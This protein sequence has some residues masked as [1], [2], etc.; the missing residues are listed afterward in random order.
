MQSHVSTA[1]LEAIISFEDLNAVKAL[2][3][4]ATSPANT[5][6]SFTSNIPGDYAFNEA[7]PI[8][9]SNAVPVSSL[10]PD[11][12]SPTWISFSLGMNTGELTLTYDETIN[13]SS[14][15]PALITLQNSTVDPSPL[16]NLTSGVVSSLNDPLLL[17]C[18]SEQDFNSLASE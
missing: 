12:T 13:A 15:N 14:L 9:S 6:L 2:L 8:A 3:D 4:L 11:T 7:E 16:F 5:S 17:V 1:T 10:I 18:L